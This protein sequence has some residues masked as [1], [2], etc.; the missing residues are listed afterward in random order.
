MEVLIKAGL[1]LIR[2]EAMEKIPEVV[3][4]AV[5]PKI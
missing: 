5:V 3:I 4:L 1:L 2:M